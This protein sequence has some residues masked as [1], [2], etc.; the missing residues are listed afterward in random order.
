MLRLPDFK[1]R[2]PKTVR[3]AA[4]ILAGE[5]P[6]AMLVAGGT[7]LWPKMKRRQMEPKVVI[8]L[9]HL[10]ELHAVSGSPATGVSLGANFTL[11]ELERYPM[12][13][14]KYPAVAEGARSISS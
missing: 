5:G 1:F 6:R 3:E 9:R 14:E 8:G 2:R 13:L 11:R 4:E 7:D 10:S 12:L